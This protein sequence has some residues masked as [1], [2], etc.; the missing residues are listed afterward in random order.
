MRQ[1]T[2]AGQAKF[3]KYGWKSRRELF[4]DEIEL[5]VPSSGLLALVHPHYV[6]AGDRRRPVALDIMLRTH[7]V[8]Q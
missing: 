4:L 5:I 6:I 1:P 7:F 8:Q 2:F 3:P